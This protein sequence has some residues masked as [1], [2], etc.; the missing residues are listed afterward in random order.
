MNV[1][2]NMDLIRFE[3][4]VE[5]ASLR[6]AALYRQKRLSMGLVSVAM[7]IAGASPFVGLPLIAVGLV[8]ILAGVL[9]VSSV[10]AYQRRLGSHRWS[11][12]HLESTFDTFCR[13]YSGEPKF[14]DPQWVQVVTRARWLL[15]ED[16]S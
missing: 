15:N 14:S 3:L 7:L 9:V 4:A 6:R 11:L 8:G 5:Q 13:R 10:E 2:S 1:M 12:N 16:K